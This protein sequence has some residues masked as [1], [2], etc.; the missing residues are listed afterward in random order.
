MASRIVGGINRTYTINDNIHAIKSTHVCWFAW[1]LSM[2][3]RSMVRQS[4]KSGGQPTFDHS[5]HFSILGFQNGHRMARAPA[6][7]AAPCHV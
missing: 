5:E 6:F 1:P 4:S 2:E 3:M 7:A